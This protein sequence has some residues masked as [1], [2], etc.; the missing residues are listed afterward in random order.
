MPRKQPSSPR[1]REVAVGINPTFKFVLLIVVGLTILFFAGAF[2]L[3]TAFNP[4]ENINNLSQ[5]CIALTSGGA[6]A[7]FGLL[8]GKVLP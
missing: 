1:S 6:G 5:V 8:G 3:A 7:V 2:V 4:S